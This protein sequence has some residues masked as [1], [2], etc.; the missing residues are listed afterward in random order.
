[1]KKSAQLIGAIIGLII[2]II[3]FFINC[4][5]LFNCVEGATCGNP[6]ACIQQILLITVVFVIVGFLVG[7]AFQKIKSK[8]TKI[9]LIVIVILIAL[10]LLFIRPYNIH[11][12]TDC[13]PHPDISIQKGICIGFVSQIDKSLDANISDKDCTMHLMGSQCSGIKIPLSEIR[14]G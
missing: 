4:W 3:L 12:S 9:I 8:R 7:W 1:M 2:G 14:N 10:S 11:K 5:G 6:Y 13:Y